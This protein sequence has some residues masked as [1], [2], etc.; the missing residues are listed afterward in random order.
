[1][2]ICTK[3]TTFVAATFGCG[4]LFFLPRASVPVP[5]FKCSDPSAVSGPWVESV[6]DSKS[7]GAAFVTLWHYPISTLPALWTGCRPKRVA[8]SV[9]AA[10]ASMPD[11]DFVYVSLPEERD[12]PASKSLV[13]A[14]GLLLSP[15]I[16]SGIC[17]VAP[18]FTSSPRRGSQIRSAAQRCA[19]PPPVGFGSKA[20]LVAGSCRRHDFRVHA[21]DLGRAR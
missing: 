1:M 18:R 5:C 14:K 20:V 7:C 19:S 4:H 13:P 2:A 6:Y 11:A 9:S 12:A 15:R 17:W 10:L 16:Y 8:E 3:F 21:I